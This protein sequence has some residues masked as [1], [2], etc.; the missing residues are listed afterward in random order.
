T[1]AQWGAKTYTLPVGTIKVRFQARSDFGNNAYFD[2]I[3]IGST[4]TLTGLL[5]YNNTAVTG[6]TNSDVRLLSGT[7]QIATAVTGTGGAYTINAIPAGSYTVTA[8]TTKPWGGVNG[9]DA[10]TIN[11]HFSGAVPLVGLRL[12]AG[13]VNMNVAVNSQDALLVS[14]RFSGIT[15]TFSA[16]N[17]AFEALPVN[18]TAG[19][20]TQNLL[21]LCFG[22]VNG[23]YSGIPVRSNA[24][25]MFHENGVA[26]ELDGEILLPVT[27]GK[28]MEIGAS[29]LVFELPAG[30]EVLGVENAL[31]GSDFMYNVVNG[32]LR[33]VWHHLDGARLAEGD[34][35]M[36][37]RARSNGSVQ[38]NLVATA[39]C[40]LSTLWAEAIDGA[41]L[42]IPALVAKVKD[43]GL[44]AYPNPAQDLSVV[45]FNL[46]NSTSVSVK[47]VDAMG[48]VVLNQVLANRPAGRNE[49]S[50]DTKGIANGVYSL[51]LSSDLNGSANLQTLKLQ[52]R[53]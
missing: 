25:V 11:R 31:P 34:V 12:K 16:G 32:Q 1:A 21:G 43:L 37:I 22:D 30:L 48:R 51:V 35:L 5:R 23:S 19:T 50:L 44:A 40:E 53:H 4:A 33:S 14:R 39:E 42:R 41:S 2:N 20:V 6:L 24:P 26:E 27:A 45:R 18:I 7:A 13:D 17:W 8:A 52:V 36:T 29:S 10:L 47:L 38:S 28:A 46:S 9:A 3:E 49:V 15:S